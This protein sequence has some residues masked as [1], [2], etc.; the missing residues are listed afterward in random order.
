MI[1]FIAAAQMYSAGAAVEKNS[2][3]SLLE[4]YNN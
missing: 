4:L 1:N 3:E 2:E